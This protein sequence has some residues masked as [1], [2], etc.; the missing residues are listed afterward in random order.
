MIKRV[1]VITSNICLALFF[2][3][4][5]WLCVSD[6][7]ENNL[8]SILSL[9]QRNSD[10][11]RF[12]MTHNT[13]DMHSFPLI[14]TIINKKMQKI[15]QNLDTIFGMCSVPKDNEDINKDPVDEKE[16]RRL[17]RSVVFNTE[18]TLQVKYDDTL[19]YGT[20]KVKDITHL[21]EKVGKDISKET[22]P[23]WFNR[24]V[25]E[26]NCFN[27]QAFLMT[28]MIG[29]EF[30]QVRARGIRRGGRREQIMVVDLQKKELLLCLFAKRRVT[31]SNMEDK[32]ES[33]VKKIL[34]YRSLQFVRIL[35][36]AVNNMTT[37]TIEQQ[38]LEDGEISHVFKMFV[39]AMEDE[40]LDML[41]FP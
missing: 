29:E 20:K 17:V 14:P 18:Q 7:Y 13:N 23:I 39:L 26:G 34:P 9:K 22:F 38:L 37:D 33:V 3:K 40:N 32:L 15:H 4:N 24:V 21:M 6:M 31:A 25:E 27:F 41:L 8:A 10:R 12:F 28:S 19:P 1:V 30:P 11:H 35:L 16:V 2:L 5:D 36:D